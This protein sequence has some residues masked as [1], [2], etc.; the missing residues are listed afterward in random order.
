MMGSSE[1]GP[2]DAVRHP[3]LRAA[4]VA[5]LLVL[6]VVGLPPTPAEAAGPARVVS[7]GSRVEKV[8]ALTFDDGWGRA[9][10]DR[11]LQT[12]LSEDVTATFF[13]YALAVRGNPAFWRKVARAGFPIANHSYS[14]PYMPGLSQH[15]ME[16]QIAASRRLIESI[17]GVPMVRVFRPPYGAYDG[18]VLAAAA[19]QGFPTVLMWDATAGDSSRWPSYR[20][21]LR[22][23]TSGTNGSV[24]LL[25]AGPTITSDALRDIIRTYKARGFRFVTIPEL[26][27]AAAAPW[28]TPSPRP[29]PTPTPTPSATP[30]PA[31]TGEPTPTATPSPEPTG[32][33][34]P[35]ATP[36]APT[37]APPPPW[38]LAMRPFAVTML[39]LAPAFPRVVGRPS[40]IAGDVAS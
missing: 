40:P 31:P 20:S 32:G 36:P 29:S 4:L 2:I 1:E 21:V 23:A 25:H 17:T 37:P 26:L 7:H 30:S 12:L 34:G 8:V 16:W 13:P 11:I 28:P 35:T 10:N 24:V 33:P 27:G 39:P 19:N 9:A 5:A 3:S 15:E 38:A 14:H 18:R 6:V 22:G